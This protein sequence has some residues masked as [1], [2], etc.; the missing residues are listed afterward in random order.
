[1]SPWT[2]KKNPP[3]NCCYLQPCLHFFTVRF[4]AMWDSFVYRGLTLSSD[5]NMDKDKRS[6][7]LV[8]ALPMFSM[9]EAPAHQPYRPHYP[10]LHFIS[11]PSS[12][13]SMKSPWTSSRNIRVSHGYRRPWSTSHGG[14]DP[15]PCSHMGL[16]DVK[17]LCPGFFDPTV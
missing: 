16:D 14:R 4:E 5:A 11:N 6:L 1:L 2:F 7:S 15:V 9:I 10:H 13:S 3:K 12:A 17:M 8:A